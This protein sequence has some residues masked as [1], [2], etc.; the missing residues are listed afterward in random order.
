MARK[1]QSRGT[2]TFCGKDMAKGGLS[3]HLKSC[4]GRKEA[5]EQ[6][7]GKEQNI[8]HLQVQDAWDG[9]YWLHLEMN[10]T[11]KLGELDNYLRAIWLECCG[12]MSHF[13]IGGVWSGNELNDALQVDKVFSTADALDH[14]YDY[15]TSN[16]TKVKVV[17]VRKGSPL[18]KHPIM[19]MGRNF[20]PEAECKSCE[21]QATY[22]CMECIYEQQESGLLCDD[23]AKDHAC[24]DYGGPIAFVNSPRVGMCGYTG[25]AD[26]PY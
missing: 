12:H 16:E 4:A 13:A 5:V 2:C 21:K 23:H 14:V 22:L 24:E 10:G 6:A 17:G 19:L 7:S 1:A 3:R 26:P 9:M 11:A 18:T 15:G 20:L 8:Y 25:P